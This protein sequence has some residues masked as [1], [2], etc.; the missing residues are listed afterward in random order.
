VECNKQPVVWLVPSNFLRTPQETIMTAYEK[1]NDQARPWEYG[2]ETHQC[3]YPNCNLIAG[4]ERE[5]AHVT[6]DV[7]LPLQTIYDMFSPVV[8]LAIEENTKINRKYPS[9]PLYIHLH[10]ECAAEWGMQLIKDAL[11]SNDR[12]GRRLS[13]REKE[14][15]R[16][17]KD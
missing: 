4:I 2:E 16:Y 17:D 7:R 1:D 14:W 9:K 6:W 12:V 13:N 15:G 11:N 3:F 8:K 5:D 10:P